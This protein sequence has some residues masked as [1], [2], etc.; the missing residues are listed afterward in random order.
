[1]SENKFDFQQ[2]NNLDLLKQLKNTDFTTNYAQNFSV[3]QTDYSKLSFPAHEHREEEKVYWQQSIELLKSIELNTANL[4]MI[5]DLINKNNENQ[6]E[7]IGI[8]SEVLEIA[9]A[10][11]KEEA[12]NLYRK[13]MK[14]ATTFTKDVEAIQ[15]LTVFAGT[16]YTLVI[17]NLDKIE[18]AGKVVKEVADKIIK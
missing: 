13:I 17:N 8:L 4:A 12:D 5:V 15:K 10:K 6:D 11:N 2:L 9:K 18:Q 1:M 3:P 16:M 14:K 7:I